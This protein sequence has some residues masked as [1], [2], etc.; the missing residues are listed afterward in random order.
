[1]G[2]L[3]RKTPTFR[4]RRRYVSGKYSKL[5]DLI[6]ASLGVGDLDKAVQKPED[7]SQNEWLAANLVDFC[8]VVNILY[9]SVIE[10]NLCT[11]QTCPTMTVSPDYEYLWMDKESPDYKEPT[12][13]SAPEYMGLLMGWIDRQLD[14]PKLFPA[15]E[16]EEYPKGFDKSVKKIFTRINRVFGHLY[17]HHLEEMKSSGLEAHLNTTCKHFLLFLAA[18]KML[19]PSKELDP[20]KSVARALLG[21]DFVRTSFK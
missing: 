3:N 4:P 10:Q 17:H 7:S 18:N 20:M 11:E 2:I 19:P 15:E 13:V 6:R 8:N 9:G 5:H 14:D 16:G 12:S 21:E 1:M